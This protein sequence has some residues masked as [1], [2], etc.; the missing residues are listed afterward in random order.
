MVDKGKD[1]KKLMETLAKSSE[2]QEAFVKSGL[3]TE[4][5]KTSRIITTIESQE[6]E[7]TPREAI[8]AFVA[9]LT[10]RE[11]VVTMS[12]YH[13]SAEPCDLV[14]Q[15]CDWNK[16]SECRNDYTERYKIPGEE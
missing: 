14:K 10:T 5:A 1:M 8:T 13:N 9:W 16:W 4:G 6:P 11:T 7:I 12:M 3:S 15:F 2:S